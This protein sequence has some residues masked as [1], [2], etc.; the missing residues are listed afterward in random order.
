M[1]RSVLQKGRELLAG[2]YCLYAAT[3][4][5]VLA[6][7]GKGTHVFALDPAVGDFVLQ[8]A[9]VRIPPRGS[10]Y[11]LNE[12]READWPEGLRRYVA[13]MKQGLGQTKASYDLVRALSLRR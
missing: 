4:L 6:L 8:R 5:F 11:S 12:G 2:G 1:D 7:K 3:T 9:S 10:S 13:D